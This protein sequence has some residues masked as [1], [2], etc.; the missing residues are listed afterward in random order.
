[1]Q[2]RAR[3]GGVCTADEGLLALTVCKTKVARG[4]QLFPR[5][6]IVPPLGYVALSHLVRIPMPLH[7]FILQ[8]P[9]FILNLCR[10][11]STAISPSL[12]PTPVTATSTP[13][14]PPQHRCYLTNPVAATTATMPPLA[15]TLTCVVG[16]TQPTSPLSLS[17]CILFSSFYFILV[18]SL[19]ISN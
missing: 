18:I 2:Q 10:T 3:I 15:P 8:L 14:L 7:S 16:H 17:L 12:P 6:C 5:H 11:M 9:P 13:P 4:K 19:F 1:M